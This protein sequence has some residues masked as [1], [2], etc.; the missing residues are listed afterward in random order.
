MR[1]S[2][3]QLFLILLF[4][5]TFS[6]F[7]QKNNYIKEAD[8]I[9]VYVGKEKIQLHVLGDKIVRVEAT[10]SG[11]SRTH[12]S[13]I[14]INRPYENI[15]WKVREEA[16]TIVLET[17]SIQANVNL[18]T[19]NIQFLDKSG[20]NLLRENGREIIPSVV[21]D[22]KINSVKQKFI[23]SE[24]EALYGLGQH[25]EGHMN[26]RGKTVDLYQ[27]N[28][29][30]SVP[31]LVS[32]KGY[33]ILWDNYSLSKFSDSA[34]GME[35]WSE[36]GDGIDYYF[37]AGSSIDEVISG[38]RTLTGQ[39]PMYAKWAYGF[40]Q[41]KER[42]QTQKEV[43]GIVDEFRQRQVPLDVIVQDWYCSGTAA[44]GFTLYEPGSLS[45]SDN[46]E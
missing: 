35:L 27:A 39:A 43:I 29:N 19:G 8:G 15:K 23:L 46:N 13:L 32:T 22:E 34:Q 21:L 30:V 36:V 6:G 41:S 7:Q 40:F 38:Y 4:F 2:I 42:Y 24:T 33:G 5:I 17:G 37:I 28:M 16:G 9:L 10:L 1:S 31:V 20:E 3:I 11:E 44:M 14:I 12:K 26:L 45:G 25:Q 18:S